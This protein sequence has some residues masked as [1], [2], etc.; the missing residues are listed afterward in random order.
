M[1]LKLTPENVSEWKAL[2]R[3]EMKALYGYEN[4]D[5]SLYDKEWLE[6]YEGDTPQ[7]AIQCEVEAWEPE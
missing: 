3:K 2:L 6:L 7:Y 5:E 4:Y 1:F